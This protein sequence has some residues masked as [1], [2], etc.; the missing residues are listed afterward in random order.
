MFEVSTRMVNQWEN[1]VGSKAQRKGGEL[2]HFRPITCLL[3]QLMRKLFTAGMLVDT[4]IMKITCN[5]HR[6]SLSPYRNRKDVEETHEAQKISC[7]L[8]KV[9]KRPWNGMGGL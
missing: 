6:K 1:C 8:Q 7:L 2:S 3:V 9:Q 5:L 4:I